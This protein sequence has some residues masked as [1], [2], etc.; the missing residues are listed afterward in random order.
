MPLNLFFFLSILQE[1]AEKFL[2][3]SQDIDSFLEEYLEK[4]QEAHLHRVKCDKMKELISTQ[5]SGIPMHDPV[6]SRRAPPVPQAAPY[7]PSWGAPNSYNGPA[8]SP[9]SAGVPMPMPMNNYYR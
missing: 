4:R 8:Y 7:P 5:G 9:Q 1:L 2:D 3:G 6:I